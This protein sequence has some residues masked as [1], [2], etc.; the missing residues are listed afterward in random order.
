[1]S[2]IQNEADHQSKIR[3]EVK[4]FLYVLIAVAAGVV[5]YFLP[6][7]MSEVSRRALSVTVFVL[8]MFVTEAVPLGVT[9]LLGCWLYWVFANIPVAKA[10]AGFH[11]DSPWF[12]L[13]ALLLGIMADTTGLAKRLAYNII[14]RLGTRYTWILLGMILLNFLLTFLIPSSVA[15]TVL[16]C[17]IAIGLIQTY[18]LDKKSNIGR[19]LILVMT[20]LSSIFDKVILTGAGNILSRGIIESLGKAQVSYGMWLIAFLPI[21]ILTMLGCW[22]L[23]MWLFP[24]EKKTLEGGAE[25]C[26]AELAK[27]G[28]MSRTEIKA[29]IILGGTTLLWAT[30]YWHHVSASKIGIIGGLFACLPLVGVI[31]KEDFGKANFPIVIFI[32]AVMCLG[33]VMAET[34]ILKTLTAA[35]FKWMTPILASASI[36]AAMLLYWYSNLLHLFLADLS[37]ISAAMPP[38]MDFCL[39]S[40]FNPLTLGMLWAF[41]LGGKVFIYQQSALAVGYA[42]GYFTP[43]DLFKFG[44]GL[45]FIES[46]LLLTIVPF[47]WPLLGLTFR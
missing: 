38:L 9:G 19:S 34:E 47:Y 26:R 10:F 25:F 41:S 14:S 27:M 28:P 22:L 8:A 36:S 45:F 12:I 5:T 17:A 15:K 31:K 20:F 2:H 4:R 16:V 18:G 44:L 1:M 40:G 24:P 43:K 30:D 21:T 13:S 42:F 11:N 35:V 7:S 46:F 29:A 37:L 32:G 33:S 3:P 6:L 23:T 39:K